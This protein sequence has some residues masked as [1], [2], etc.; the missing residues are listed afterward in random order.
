MEEVVVYDTELAWCAGFFDGEGTTSYLKKDNW[1]GPRMS[2]AQNNVVPLERFQKAVGYGKIYA[3][4]TRLGMFQWTCQRKDDV[5]IVLDKL[6]P[7]LCEQ[8]KEQALSIF[9]MVADNQAERQSLKDK[10]SSLCGS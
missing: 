8:K 6:W 10:E 4:T 2:V 9:K 1:I 5:K 7:F 3:H